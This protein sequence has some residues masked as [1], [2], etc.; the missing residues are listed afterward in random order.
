[1]AIAVATLACGNEKAKARREFNRVEAALGMVATAGP[2]ERPIRLEQLQNLR[3]DSAQLESLRS[4]CIKSYTAFDSASAA[5]ERAKTQ[6]ARVESE[7]LRATAKKRDGG[8]LAPEEE[9][10]LVEMSA[11]AARS[12][13]TVTAALEEAQGLVGS[14][15]RKREALRQV[16]LAE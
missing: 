16:Y 14:C 6:T 10:R 8:V 3:L 1:M 5:L 2:E 12:I 7:V 15:Q 9:T 11:Q 4:L 13:E